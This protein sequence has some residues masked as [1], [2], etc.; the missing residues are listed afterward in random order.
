MRE[1]NDEADLTKFNHEN[2]I[3]VLSGDSDLNLSLGSTEMM[4]SAAVFTSS[5]GDATTW[6]YVPPAGSPP[7][8]AGQ[9]LGFTRDHDGTTVP[10]TPDVDA[11][12]RL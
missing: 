8:G 6:N 2:N 3:Y 4:T 10:T 1:A 9:S 7:L 12:Q 11:Y 5:S